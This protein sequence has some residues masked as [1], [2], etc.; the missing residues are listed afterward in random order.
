MGAPKQKWTP[1]EEAAL[2][3]GVLKHG[4]GKWRTIL[5]D[6]QF[7]GVLY[8]R[9]NV[10]LKDKWRNM[11]VM[12]NGWGS[13]ER[14]RLALKRIHPTPKRGESSMPLSSV[15]QSDD[16]L[17]DSRTHAT[18]GGSSQNDAPKRSIMRL[19]NLIMEAIRN[20]RQPGGSNKTSIAAYIEELYWAPPNFKRILSAKLRHFAANGKLIKLKRKYR[21]AEPSSLPERRKAA[22]V[23]MEGRLRNSQRIDL[24]DVSQLSKSQID[25]ELTKMR[26]MTPQEAA[27]AAAQAVAE[28]EAAMAEAEEAAREAEAA[29]ADAEAAQAFAEAALKTLRGRNSS[30]TVRAMDPNFS[31][32]EWLVARVQQLESERNEL[33]KDIEQLCM[34]QAGPAYL[35]VATRMHFQRIAALEQ[36][37]ESL[38]KKL[39]ACTRENQNLQEELSEAYVI[40]NAE[41]EKQLKFF[42]GCVAAAFA[43]RDNAILE[44]EKAKEKVELMPQELNKCQ[45]RVEE[46]SIELLEEKELTTSLRIDLEKHERQIGIFKEVID[47]FYHIRECTMEDTTDASWEEKC[48]LLLHDSDEMWRFQND[49]DAS[50]SNYINSLEAEIE[51]LRRRIDNLQNK[52]QVGLEIETHLKKKVRKLEKMEKLGAE[53]IKEQLSALKHHHS[54][55]KND[56]NDLLDGG[57]SELKSLHELVVEKMSHFV[58][59]QEQSNLEASL[60]QDEELHESECKDVHVNADSSSGLTTKN[61]E[62]GLPTMAARE[63]SDT[64]EAL[65]L[66]LQEKVEALLLLSQQ[67]ERHL[68]ERNVNA[69]LQKKVEELQRNLLQVTNEKVKALMELAQLRQDQYSLHEKSSQESVQGKPASEIFGGEIKAGQEKDSKLKNLLRKSYLTRWVGGSEGS[70]A[71]THH[72]DFARMKIENATLK[73]SLE[74]MDHL[75]SSVRRLRIS[76]FKV[77][78]SSNMSSTENT[79]YL[80]TT[81]DQIIVE[82]DLVRTAL[83]S[84]I[85]ISWSAEADQSHDGSGFEKLDFVSAVGFEMVELLIFAAQVL[86]DQIPLGTKGSK[87]E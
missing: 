9:S 51:T 10:D 78:D 68:L 25:L 17:V 39:A 73:E 61:N 71:D 21:I 67:E 6:P 64:S 5:K 63:T 56:I 43:E 58:L 38:N 81:I 57:Y 7:S 72:M 35:G 85:P 40:K 77:K 29:E 31:G 74:S 86:R 65:A 8:L 32:N 59:S 23:P 28:A 1:E 30:I 37:I 60:T 70:G 82:A 55:Y 3:A 14:S 79:S 52:L 22:S 87:L 45:R 62:H 34:Q 20:L 46:L 4:P 48:E 15:S 54:Q 75:L 66:A 53:N 47:K 13:R 84:S 11:S 36:D 76:L 12:S 24:E 49:E 80:S 19:D 41:A 26:N 42:Q 18:S 50:T 33:H 83:G 2:K 16:D 69:A 44:A 27:V